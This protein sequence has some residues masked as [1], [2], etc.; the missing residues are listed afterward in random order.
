MRTDLLI[1]DVARAAARIAGQVVR[2]PALRLPELDA[3]TGA[4]VVLKTE[5]HQRTGAFKIRGALNKLL[6]LDPGT[7]R[8]VVA[9]SSG[10]HGRAVAALAEE[11]GLPAVLVLP[12]DAPATKVA[13]VLAH[14]ARVVRYDPRAGDRDEIVADI[15][16]RDGFAVLA[17]SDDPDVAAG[18]GTVAL[19]LFEQAGAL[20]VLVVPVGGGGLAAGCATVA[21]ARCP[22]IE[23]V[24]VEPAGG[25]DTARSLA[26]GRRVTVPTP[27]TLADGL[28]HRV[29]GRF[30]FAV[31]RRLLDRVVSVEDGEI[32][33]AMAFLWTRGRLTA[34]P[35]GACATAAALAGRLETAGRRVGVVVSGGNVAPQQFHK[36]AKLRP[37]R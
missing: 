11:F 26:A 22:W 7:L 19:E 30:T 2:T 34:E 27:D 17:S 29:P 25:D 10:N 16:R 8:G 23:V 33:A 9:G 21:K 31:N 4:V 1:D 6:T 3:A 15:A 35:S 36:I 18:H 5:N 28:R 20:D 32:A 14:G 13:A 37:E 24:G 12:S